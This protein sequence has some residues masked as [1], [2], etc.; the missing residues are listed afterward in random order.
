[1]SH[2]TTCF[3]ARWASTTA[4]FTDVVLTSRGVALYEYDG[5]KALFML[6]M[7]PRLRLALRLR[8]ADMYPW[9]LLASTVAHHL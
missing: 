5:T 1:M 9:P 3:S 4:S 8:A 7:I 6:P 2:G